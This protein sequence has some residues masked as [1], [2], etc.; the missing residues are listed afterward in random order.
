[1]Y[2]FGVPDEKIKVIGEAWQHFERIQEDDYTE[3]KE[4][5]LNKSKYLIYKSYT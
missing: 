3:I 5:D 4:L 2:H 1:M